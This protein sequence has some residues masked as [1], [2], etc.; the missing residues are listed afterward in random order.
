VRLLALTDPGILS[1]AHEQHRTI[2]E[3]VVTKQRRK[4]DE[5][6]SRHL[7]YAPDLLEWVEKSHPDY[8]VLDEDVEESQA[9]R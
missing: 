5:A 3:F 8:F 1:G 2:V 7:R 6:L 9:V 4:A